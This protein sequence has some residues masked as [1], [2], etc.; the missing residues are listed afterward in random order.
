MLFG[1]AYLYS[2]TIT[3]PKSSKTRGLLYLAQKALN[4][5]RYQS[6]LA[7]FSL[8]EEMPQPFNLEKEYL[9]DKGSFRETMIKSV[10][11]KPDLA[12]AEERSLWTSKE[13]KTYANR[14]KIKRLHYLC[15]NGHA[16]EIA[17]FL[18]HPNYSFERLEEYRQRKNK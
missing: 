16:T 10:R 14:K 2:K 8:A 9:S 5:E 15:G 12:T 3:N 6:K 1:L 13:L 4:D 7:E 18:R 11:L 17:Y